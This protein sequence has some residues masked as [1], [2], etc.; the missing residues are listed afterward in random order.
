MATCWA[1]S[2]PP[3]RHLLHTSSLG[4]SGFMSTTPSPWLVRQLRESD[5]T[6]ICSWVTSPRALSLVSSDLGDHLTASIF[7]RWK[8][9]ALQCLVVACPGSDAPVAFCS[10]SQSESPGMPSSYLEL[11]HLIVRLRRLYVPLGTR[12]A[13]HAAQVAAS[14]TCSFV[15]ARVLP[16]NRH[17]LRLAA[18]LKAEE[19]SDIDWLSPG[20]CWFRLPVPFTWIT[21]PPGALS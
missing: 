10:V 3:L 21:A 4:E 9:H 7:H 12:L 1:P 15:C 11:C 8:S 5:E 20:F 6:E 2:R 18:Y 16:E 14:N 13:Q 17:G 19:F